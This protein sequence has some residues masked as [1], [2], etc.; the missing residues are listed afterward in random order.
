MTVILFSPTPLV[1]RHQVGLR[2]ALVRVGGVGVSGIWSAAVPLY[3]P[4]SRAD[5]IRIIMSRPDAFPSTDTGID[6]TRVAGR[7]CLQFLLD[8]LIV[9]VP[10]IM[11]GIIATVVV[12]T[13]VGPRH[14]ALFSLV[15]LSVLFPLWIAATLFFDTWW[16][17]R[18]GGQTP[19]MRW[20][21]LR[22]VSTNGGE[23]PLRAY[24]VRTVLLVV[25]GFLWG[26]LGLTLILVS[27]R[28]QRLGDMVAHT[29]VVR[30]CA[31]GPVS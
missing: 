28:R 3:R 13:T 29:L 20:L 19:A 17:H 25:D 27:S 8:R 1:A 23:P 18:H 26:L 14:L 7:R 5:I 2:F 15:L 4:G 6:P 31:V 22:V 30:A 16:P 11:L 21:G 24:L 10:V 9:G 12:T